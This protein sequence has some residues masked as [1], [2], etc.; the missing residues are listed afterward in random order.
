MLML[1]ARDAVRRPG[2]GLEA[3]ADDYLVKPFAIEEL[4]ARHARADSARRGRDGGERSPSPTSRSTCATRTAE[5]GGRAGRADR[6]RERRCSSCCCATRAAVVPRERA[7]EQIW[8]EAAVPN[9]VDRYVGAAAPQAR[10]AAAHPH[11][12]RRGVHAA[13]VR[14]RTLTGA[15]AVAA[16][17]GGDPRRRRALL[18]VAAQRDRRRSSCAPRSTQPAPARATDVARLSVSAPG[19]AD[20]AGRAGG[21]GRR[22]A[23]A[24]SRCST[25]RAH[26]GPLARPRRRMLPRDRAGDAARC[27]RARRLRRL[28]LGGEP[29]RLYAA[30]LPRGGGPAA[31]GAVLVASE[32]DRHR[33]HAAPARPAAAARRARRRAAAALAAALLTR[34]G[35]RPL[36]AAVRRPRAE[37][38]RTGDPAPAAA[39]RHD[40]RRDRAS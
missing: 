39:A 36:R 6:A 23:A 1:T 14:P 17:L 35:L 4:V 26:R 27:A 37:I 9:V 34:R 32:H 16:S 33:A 18:G 30:P 19:A 22:A 10:G 5:R 8:D 20:R 38:E 28:Q 11:R 29:L 13:G 25:A 15:S 31:G 3:G 12:A 24:R 21:T 40:R 2:R 7:I